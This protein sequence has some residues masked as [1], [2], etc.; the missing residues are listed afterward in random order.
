MCPWWALSNILKIV[1]SLTFPK[2]L[3]SM[4]RGVARILVRLAKPCVLGV[5]PLVSGVGLWPCVAQP[6]CSPKTKEQ[7]N[8]KNKQDGLGPVDR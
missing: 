3:L 6:S 4:R 2:N 7:L 1:L 8:E 5:S